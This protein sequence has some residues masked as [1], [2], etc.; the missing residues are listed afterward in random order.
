LGTGEQAGERRAGEERESCTGIAVVNAHKPFAIVRKGIAVWI[1]Q[2]AYKFCH[3]VV[4]VRFESSS[5]QPDLGWLAAVG[6]PHA[7]LAGCAGEA[8]QMKKRNHWKPVRVLGLDGA[9]VSGWSE[10]QPG[11]WC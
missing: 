4:D 5:E 6:Q 1:K 9:Y 10:K 7:V 8:K 2:S 3:P 11:W